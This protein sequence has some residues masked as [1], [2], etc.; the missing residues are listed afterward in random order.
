MN[1]RKT[2]SAKYVYL[3]PPR[4]G[5]G[6]MAEKI[7]QR[8]IAEIS[9]L[10]ESYKHTRNVKKTTSR[11]ITISLLAISDK[12]KIIKQLKQEVMFC[13]KEQINMKSKAD[14][15]LETMEVRRQWNDTCKVLKQNQPVNLEFYVW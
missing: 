4:E 10:D 7:F 11:C 3:E 1:C 2:S 9:K 15:S 5:K 6:G 12:N 14:F 8:I 13:T